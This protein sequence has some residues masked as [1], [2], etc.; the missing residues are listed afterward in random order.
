MP[1]DRPTFSESWYRVA[2]LRP[3][4]RST[5]QV[6]RQHF[7]GQLWY[8]LED[9][10]SNQF[11]RVSEAA[12]RFVGLL[13]GRRTVAQA[14]R[15]T[16]EHLGDAAPTQGEAINLLGQLYTSNLLYA[17]LPP[18]AEGLFRRYRRRVTREVQGYLLN[19]LFVRI[20]LLDPD[21]IL[22]R[23]AGVVGRLFTW[24]GF[25]LW[26]ILIGFGLHAVIGRF[27]EL[28]RQSEHILELDNLWLLY[29]SMVIVKVI[30][31][32]SHAFACKWF[33]RR[34]GT[35][36][37]VH[38]MGVMLLVFMPL[39]YM[40]ASSAWAFR[41]K[42]R[43]AVV[44]AAGMLAELAIAAVA[45]VVW[46]RTAPGTLRTIA[47]NVIFIA[48]VSTLL[49]N[50]NPLLRFDGYYIL[51]DLLEIPNLYQ[52]ARGYLYYLARRYAWGVRRPQNPAHSWGERAW[53]IVY[54]LASLVFRIFISI[55][56]ILFL[57]NRLPKELFFVAVGFGLGALVGWIVVPA[58][59]FVRYL[60]TSGEL[61]RVRLRAVLSTVVAVALLAGGL[62]VVPAPERHRVEGIVEPVEF[63]VV[64]MGADGFVAEYLPSDREVQPDGPPLVKAEN[65][66]LRDDH[67]LL[68]LDIDRMERQRRSAETEAERQFYE[69][70][71][72]ML[73][74]KKRPRLE[75]EIAALDLAPPITGVWIAPEIDETLGRYLKRG[76]QVG[77]VARPGE[78]VIRV[79]ADQD[80]GP[81][82]IEKAPPRK[83]AN[84][85]AGAAESLH[86]KARPEVEVRVR[87]R[88]DIHLV[89]R[90]ERVLPAGQEELPFAALAVTAG[91][92]V[93]VD[94]Q[95]P[96]GR[97]AAERLFEIRIRP[98]RHDLLHLGQRVIVR[99]ELPPRPLAFQAWHA[100]L[101]LIQRRYHL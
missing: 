77:L 73:R 40:D 90:I 60:A 63:E 65:P 53:F 84:E 47:F 41:S 68:L 23:W 93:Q 6:C 98:E 71:L 51:S 2:D 89:G 99:F 19:L 80:V 24:P 15:T 62:G 36:G 28:S 97:Q 83:R 75:R 37:E 74:E 94:P 38:V 96:K 69:E 52:R 48:S 13:D 34:E 10:A 16:A 87:R 67:N 21:R 45:A 91:G 78:V 1:V 59:K 86:L 50:G 32:F 22:E 29:A 57:G 4:L 17:D 43:R 20:P 35:G 46:S 70:R 61:E 44:G 3:R 95:D 7:R 56:I 42:W 33:G 88:P 92:S 27:G 85:A 25:I 30:H 66:D 76:E 54:G 81:M 100:L 64:H 39:P 79:F 58:V 11:F 9:P 18:D 72:A 5:V 12:Y 14:W 8:V 49:F 55:R 82:L 31:E 101:Q 26:L